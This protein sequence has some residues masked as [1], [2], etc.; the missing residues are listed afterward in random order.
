MFPKTVIHLQSPYAGKAFTIEASP[1]PESDPYI[2]NATLNGHKHTRNWIS[3]EDIRAGG[4]LG[5]T[6]G[7]RP[8][9]AW[10]S[11]ANDAPPSL[12]DPR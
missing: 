1:N 7:P 9:Q 5:F 6:V 10:G 11:E 4:A 3:F 12:S 8:N 2:Q